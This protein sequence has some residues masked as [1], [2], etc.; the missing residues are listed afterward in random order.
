MV[1]LSRLIQKKFLLNV[2]WFTNAFLRGKRHC[3]ITHL[4]KDCLNLLHIRDPIQYIKHLFPG[5]TVIFFVHFQASLRSAWDYLASGKS[6][7]IS[8][9]QLILRQIS[10]QILLKE[11]EKKNPQPYIQLGDKNIV[12]HL[13]ENSLFQ[14]FELYFNLLQVKQSK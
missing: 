4:E 11:K 1:Q 3:H 7:T 6:R 8:F 12:Q 14:R 5:N 9:V 2:K 10:N 13:E